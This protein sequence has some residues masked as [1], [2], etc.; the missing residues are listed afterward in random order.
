MSG[1]YSLSSNLGTIFTANLTNSNILTLI[2]V[3]AGSASVNVCSSNG[4]CV[5]VYVTVVNP[6]SNSSIASSGST[7]YK[8]YNPLMLGSKGA[9]V[10]ELQKRLTA[11]G[12]Y[13][14]P[15]TGYYGS[16]TEAAVKKYQTQRNIDQLGNVGPATRAALNQ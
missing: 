8:F 10:S 3:S 1:V 15:I 16:L 14:G 5:P 2:G 12:V 6:A 13:S 11:E 9:D 7:V 4:S